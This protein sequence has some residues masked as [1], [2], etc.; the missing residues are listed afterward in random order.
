MTVLTACQMIGGQNFRQFHR[1]II[2][3]RYQSTPPPA[4]PLKGEGES[5]PSLSG[6]GA[7]GLG[8]VESDLV[9][10]RS[11]IVKN[12]PIL[13]VIRDLSELRLWL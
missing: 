7:G 6:K 10:F 8:G 13:S 12:F 2:P 3:I 4:P 9:L 1:D 5:P 11:F